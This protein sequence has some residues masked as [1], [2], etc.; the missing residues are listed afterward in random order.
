MPALRNP[1]HVRSAEPLRRRL[2]G[3]WAGNGRDRD[4][5]RFWKM[6]GEKCEEAN[7]D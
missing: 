6:R 3:C 1:E 5:E 4:R 2:A 7:W